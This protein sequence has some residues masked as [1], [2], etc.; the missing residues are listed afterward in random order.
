MTPTLAAHGVKDVADYKLQLLER[1]KN[2]ALRHRT[3]QIAMDGSQKLPQR[4]LGTVRERLAAGA[5]MTRLALSVAAWMRY[6]TGVNERG[7]TIDVARSSRRAAQSDRR[8]RRA[9]RGAAR[10]GVPIGAR[11]LRQ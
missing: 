9:R 5:P 4:L 1:F 11:D 3:S 8:R 2:P 6:V 7:Q 10:S